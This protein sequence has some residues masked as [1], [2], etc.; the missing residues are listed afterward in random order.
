VSE[1]TPKSSDC[2]ECVDAERTSMI[3]TEPAGDVTSDA[4]TFT[5]H[6]VVKAVY[7]VE[8]Y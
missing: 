4:R 2:G 8:N 5:C 3:Y 1:Q 7:T 6:F